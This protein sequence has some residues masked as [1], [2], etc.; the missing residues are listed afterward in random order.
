MGV[1]R[2]FGVLTDG[3]HGR[4]RLFISPFAR[5]ILGYV[6]GTLIPGREVSPSFCNTK[7]CVEVKALRHRLTSA[8]VLYHFHRFCIW[9][10]CGLFDLLFFSGVGF[11]A[12]SPPFCGG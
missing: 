4:Y 2:L 12:F 3:R 8:A 1:F 10:H 6:Y 11:L 7:P 5:Y 9:L